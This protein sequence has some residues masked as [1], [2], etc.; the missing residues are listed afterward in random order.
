MNQRR[1]S[2]IRVSYT[3]HKTNFGSID[4]INDVSVAVTESTNRLTAAFHE[5]IP[6]KKCSE[7]SRTIVRHKGEKKKKNK[8]YQNGLMDEYRLLDNHSGK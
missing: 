6:L 3:L 4:Y 8:V 1:A 5:A 7:K 2:K